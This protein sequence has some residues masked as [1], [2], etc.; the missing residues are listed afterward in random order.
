MRDVFVLLLAVPVLQVL[1]TRVFVNA[2]AARAGVIIPCCLRRRYECAYRIPLLVLLARMRRMLLPT[3][4][5]LLMLQS[6]VAVE[7]LL[8]L[9]TLLRL[10]HRR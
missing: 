7:T 9:L 5:L 2:S 10:I 3:L 4:S 1:F 6:F 8:L